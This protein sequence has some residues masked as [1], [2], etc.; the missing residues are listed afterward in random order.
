MQFQ[1]I[2]RTVEE[3]ALFVAIVGERFTMRMTFAHQ[4]VEAN[5]RRVISRTKTWPKYYSSCYLKT[6]NLLLGQLSAWIRE[7]CNVPTIAITGSC[8]KTTVKEM[9]ASILQQRG[10]VLFTA[11]KLTSIMI[12]VAAFDFAIRTKRW[13]YVIELGAN[14][15]GEIAYT[16][17][18]KPQVALVN[19]VAAAP[20]LRRLWFYRWRQKQAKVKSFRG[21]LPVI[22]LLLIWE[23]RW[24]LLEW[25][26]CG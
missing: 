4:A 24:G 12:L 20:A 15:I 22:L 7:Q 8:G 21:L 10:K 14:H 26:P 3:G 17:L 11:W 23:Q 2:Y 25:S 18:V 19:N 9:V 1:R 5:A 6:L 16:T 13:L